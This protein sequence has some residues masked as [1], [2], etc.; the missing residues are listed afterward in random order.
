MKALIIVFTAIAA[1]V[2]SAWA[3]GR[4]LQR[5]KRMEALL[6]LK[7]GNTVYAIVAG[8]P[9]KLLIIHNNMKDRLLVCRNSQGIMM[10]VFYDQVIIEF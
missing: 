8:K 9:E 10:D 1:A 6:S 3:A 4:I 5:S 2:A 7:N